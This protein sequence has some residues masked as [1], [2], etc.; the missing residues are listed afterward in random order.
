MTKQAGK[1]RVL[2]TGV[3]DPTAPTAIDRRMECAFE[4]DGQNFWERFFPCNEIHPN[5]RIVYL[6]TEYQMHLLY[7]WLIGK[8]ESGG[9]EVRINLD[10]SRQFFFN[11]PSMAGLAKNRLG[12]CGVNACYVKHGAGN[13]L[14]LSPVFFGAPPPEIKKTPTYFFSKRFGEQPSTFP[15]F[16]EEEHERLLEGIL[17]MRPALEKEFGFP[18]LLFLLVTE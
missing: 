10:F 14:E 3:F 6:F 8:Y 5:D 1:T 16:R 13:R 11:S 12:Y 4:A 18:H 15:A 17:A 9:R 2:L 7:N